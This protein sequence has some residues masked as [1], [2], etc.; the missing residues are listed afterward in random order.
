MLKTSKET[1]LHVIL[2]KS[3]EKEHA[4]HFFIQFVL[5]FFFYNNFLFMMESLLILHK[6]IK[7]IETKQETAFTY[8][9]YLY[10]AK[11]CKVKQKYFASICI[12]Y[13]FMGTRTNRSPWKWWCLFVFIKILNNN[14][15]VIFKSS[16]FIKCEQFDCEHFINSRNS[17]KPLKNL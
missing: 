3:S 11:K 1:Y 2:Y 15:E 13:Q 17:C 12:L 6:N 10:L 9:I 4:W 5:N 8:I 7:Q 16:N 14:N